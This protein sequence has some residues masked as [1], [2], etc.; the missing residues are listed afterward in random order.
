MGVTKTGDLDA[1]AGHVRIG[2]QVPLTPS[3]YYGGDVDSIEWVSGEVYFH[4]G[5]NQLYIQTAT[6]G[7]TPVWK[8]LLE[9]F[10]AV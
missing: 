3:I 4:T 9:A 2:T 5:D 1:Q 7:T 8:R 10:A 6:S